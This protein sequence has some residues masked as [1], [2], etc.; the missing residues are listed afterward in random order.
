MRPL[1]LLTVCLT[2]L[3]LTSCAA[4]GRETTPLPRPDACVL[5]APVI[6]GTDETIPP[7]T[8]R[9]ILK[10]NRTWRCVCQK[11]CAPVAPF[12]SNPHATLA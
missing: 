1:P 5:F 3:W 8:A 4:T 7:V 9:A 6:L 10:H 11:I 12:I 2:L